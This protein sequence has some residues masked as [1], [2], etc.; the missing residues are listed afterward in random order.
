MARRIN[1]V[2]DPWSAM[3]AQPLTVAIDRL[4][5]STSKRAE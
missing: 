5:R 3:R 2:G 4:H 1:A